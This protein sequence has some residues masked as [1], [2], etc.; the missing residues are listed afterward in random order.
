[1]IHSLSPHFYLAASILFSL[2]GVFWLSNVRRSNHPGDF[3]IGVIIIL[4]A[5]IL[6]LQGLS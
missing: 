3:G 4:I 2:G 1:M 5:V 6:L